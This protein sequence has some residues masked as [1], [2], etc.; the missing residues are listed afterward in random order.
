MPPEPSPAA[1]PGGAR[2]P[3]SRGRLRN[4]PWLY[5]VSFLF[6][7]AVVVG[8]IAHDLR[9]AYRGTLAYWNVV[10]SNAATD[11]VNVVTL[12]LGERRT[13]AEVIA[14]NP[15]TAHLLS[16]TGGKGA[17]RDTRAAVERE[18]TRITSAN[19]FLAGAVLDTDC[20][21]VARAGTPEKAAEDFQSVCRFVYRTREFEVIASGYGH[22]NV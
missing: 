20:R 13:D 22:G 16:A 9:R 12:W 2:P 19:G 5:V 21:I 15:L 7:A 3:G 11:Q 10:L 8:F 1:T 17:S 6:L 18:L 14:E 4:I